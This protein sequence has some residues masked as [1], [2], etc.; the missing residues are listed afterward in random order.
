MR[1]IVFLDRDGTINQ[2]SGYVTSADRVVL[3]PN[4]AKSLARMRNAGFALVVVSNQSAV[5]RGMASLADV[6]S[7]N[8]EVQRQLLSEDSA[9]IV[10]QILF[11]TSAPGQG[12]DCRKPGVG[13][14]RDLNKDLIYDPTTSWVVGDK[15][16]D[17]EFGLN[18]NLPIRNCILVLTGEGKK[19]RQQLPKGVLVADDLAQ[20]ASF[21]V[22]GR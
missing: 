16:S 11:S 21:I 6:I 17:I 8:E 22:G 2:D 14:L 13:L 3:I 15:L 9:A 4:A 5:G 19:H 7:T 20:A 10:D 12:D 18:A 1:S